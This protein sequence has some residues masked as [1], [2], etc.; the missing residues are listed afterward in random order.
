M[1][2]AV[3]ATAAAAAA[4]AGTATTAT[5]AASVERVD[6]PGR[7]PIDQ[8]YGGFRKDVV[9]EGEGGREK[10]GGGL[11]GEFDVRGCLPD[12]W[13]GQPRTK[14]GIRDGEW[15]FRAVLTREIRHTPTRIPRGHTRQSLDW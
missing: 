13:P 7:R 4:A 6:G 5:T 1:T 15:G 11:H 14:A 3:R 2:A 9:E 10:R 8:Q 12:W